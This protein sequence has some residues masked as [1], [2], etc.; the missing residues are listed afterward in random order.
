[1][2]TQLWA[3]IL[4]IF[5]TFIGALGPILFK[6]ASDKL[7][8]NP[9]KLIKNYTL[10]LGFLFYGLSMIIYLI[11]ITGGELSVLYPLVSISYIWVSLLSIKYLNEKMNLYK[12]LGVI[13]I[14]FGVSIIGIA[15]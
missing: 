10:I 3:V 15:S 1:M 5:G 9:F 12:W 4:I 6:K 11:A 2:A 8:F 14:I 7:S 13:M